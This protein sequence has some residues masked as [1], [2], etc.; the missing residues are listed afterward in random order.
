MPNPTRAQFGISGTPM[1]STSDK[2][3]RFR[4]ISQT[5]KPRIL[6][7]DADIAIAALIGG[8]LEGEKGF[9]VL[10]AQTGADGVSIAR[11]RLPDLILLDFRLDDMS[12][13]E[14]HERLLQEP[15]TKQIPVVYVSSFLTLRMIEEASMKG[16]KGFIRKP[17]N[18]SE[19]YRKVATVL[20]ST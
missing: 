14:V 18:L 12:G 19:I 7:I 3:Y 1:K 11:K 15:S 17:F 10:T 8:Y 9:K 4:R 20:S 16:A 6:I 2:S 5:S 13:L